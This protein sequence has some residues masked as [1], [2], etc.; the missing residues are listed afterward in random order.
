MIKMMLVKDKGEAVKVETFFKAVM[1]HLNAGR[2]YT[3]TVHYSEEQDAFTDFQEDGVSIPFGALV[4]VYRNI[5][6]GEGV[7][8][9]YSFGYK[10]NFAVKK[11]VEGDLAGLANLSEDFFP[12]I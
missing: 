6:G 3:A 4:Y 10:G 1:N 2:H 9:A 7:Y 5:G 11:D 8:D 12:N